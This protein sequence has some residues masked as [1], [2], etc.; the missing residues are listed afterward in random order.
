MISFVVVVVVAADPCSWVRI[1]ISAK[2][3]FEKQIRS[4]CIQSLMPRH[5]VAL[6]RRW[7]VGHSWLMDPDAWLQGPKGVIAGSLDP[8]QQTPALLRH[9]ASHQSSP[10]EQPIL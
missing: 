7:R 5:G 8:S 10:Y 9:I 3:A 2:S 6:G 4:R 1:P